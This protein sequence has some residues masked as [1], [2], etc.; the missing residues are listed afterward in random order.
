M[1][2]TSGYLCAN[3]MHVP[4]VMKATFCLSTVFPNLKII[5]NGV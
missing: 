5:C 3:V 4:A 2:M 1:A